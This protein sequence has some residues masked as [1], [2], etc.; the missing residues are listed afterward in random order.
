MT[1]RDAPSRP[2]AVVTGATGGMGRVITR[3]L[4]TAGWH[5]VAVVRD[6]ARAAHVLHPDDATPSGV[7]EF[8]AADLSCRDCVAAATRRIRTSHERVHLLINNAGAHFS[9]HQLSADGLE[10]HIAVD[11]QASYGT[12]W[13]LREELARGRA[14]VVNVASDTLRDTRQ[15]KLGGRLRP[16][17]VD[18]RTLHDLTSL[19]PKDGFVPFEAYGRA[20]LLTVTAANGLARRLGGQGVTVNSVHPGIVATDIVDDLIPPVLRPLRGLIRRTM[21]TPEKGAASALRLAL[22]P[23]LSGVTG[24]YFVRSVDTATPPITY[25]TDAQDALLAASEQFFEDE[26]PRRRRL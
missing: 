8:V 17:T 9:S 4:V 24:R 2:V 10:M 13:L 23:E 6:A 15:V 7:V 20:K 19:N 22:D 16:P 21:L 3:A 14:R 25:D 26:S 12:T 11:Y 5:V 1:T 18:P